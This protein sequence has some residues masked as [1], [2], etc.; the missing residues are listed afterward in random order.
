MIVQNR[1][2]TF[3]RCLEVNRP[4]G[5]S[6][7]PRRLPPPSGEGNGGCLGRSLSTD[8]DELGDFDVLFGCRTSRGEGASGGGEGI[9]GL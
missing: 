4:A 7:H 6:D 5:L 1:T 9:V 8:N 3:H 2:P